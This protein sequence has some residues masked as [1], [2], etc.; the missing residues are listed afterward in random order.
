MP[1]AP[2]PF[3]KKAKFTN[4]F[5]T[6]NNPDITG[7]QFVERCKPHAQYMVFQLEKGESGTPHFQ[8]V[9]ELKKQQRGQWVMDHICKH[10]AWFDL[11]SETGGPKYCMKDDTRVEG[12]WE[13]GTRKR[14][15]TRTDKVTTNDVAARALAAPT[16]LEA[17]AI[18]KEGRPMQY[19]THG[20]QIIGNLEA[21]HQPKRVV[22]IEHPLDHYD[23]PP[24]TFE[25]NVFV[26]GESGWGKTGFVL[27]H[28]KN[29][30]LVSHIDD[31]AKHYVHGV[32]DALVF[33]DMGFS[34]WKPES[35][36]HLVDR[37]YDRSIHV[38]YG[39]C[40]IPKGVIK[41]FT[42]NRANPFYD[43]ST[44]EPGQQAA[45][46]NRLRR[47]QITKD[48]RILPVLVD[49]LSEDDVY[50]CCTTEEWTPSYHSDLDDP[51]VELINLD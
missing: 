46:W 8:G 27:A 4:L 25:K 22:D 47:V 13:F 5:F 33:D 50:E 26:Y 31:I 40:S 42:S 44:T 28:F 41:V 45:I 43:P 3:G 18:I 30:L 16:V 35:V 39:T 6:W 12:P 17:L 20:K 19:L 14:P 37:Q 23:H 10:A 32:H 24:L 34:T 7:E 36:I 29:P 51:E 1:R 2:R 48:I 15:G 21:H 11:I 38:R 9:I 49:S